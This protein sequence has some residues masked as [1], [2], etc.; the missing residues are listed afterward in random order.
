MTCDLYFSRTVTSL[1]IADAALNWSSTAFSLTDAL[2]KLLSPATVGTSPTIWDP[3][4]QAPIYH[5]KPRPTI[6]GPH[7]KQWFQSC[8]MHFSPHSVSKIHE[9]HFDQQNGS[10]LFVL[11]LSL[12]PICQGSSKIV[13][14]CQSPLPLWQSYCWSRWI[15]SKLRG[16][17][18]LCFKASKNKSFENY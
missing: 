15:L 16:S 2:V 7:T 12:I 6:S 3:Q 1:I 9:P 8:S 11:S 13:K 18:V 5:I 17:T 14:Q 4:Y 10:E